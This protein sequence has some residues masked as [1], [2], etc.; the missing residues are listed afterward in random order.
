MKNRYAKI[1]RGIIV[2]LLFIS[3]SACHNL[4]NKDKDDPET[5]Y[6][7]NYEMVRSYLPVMVESIFEQ[8]VTQF[9]EMEV[10]QERVKH[11][12]IIYKITY[13]TSFEGEPKIASGL[14]CVPTGEGEFPVISY[15]NG[16][17]TL[18]KNAPS[19]NPNYELYVLLEMVASTGFIISMPDYLG[20]GSSDNMFHPY[21]HKESTVQTV[22]DMLRAVDELASI[23]NI[24][25]N[26]ELYLTGY[27]QG[28]WATMQVH[29]AIEQEFY[30]EFNLKASAP[31]AGPYDLN[32]INEHILSQEIYPMPYFV[33]YIFNSYMNFEEMTTPIGEVFNPPYDSLI[34]VL[35]D[36]TKSGE[37]INAELTTNVAELFTENYL[38]NF[39]TDT[40][41]TSVL[42][43]LEM[44][45]IKAWNTSVPTRIIHGT[46]DNFVPAQVSVNIYQDFLSQGVSQNRVQLIPMPD[47]DHIE[48]IIPAGL[49]SI[50][51]FLELT[52]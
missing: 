32:F 4:F 13:K 9:P 12:I 35:Y 22:L 7:V 2:T 29:K 51:W 24:S 36:G 14:V 43:T 31:G 21:L 8:L 40:S 46:A 52:E 38:S 19:V 3:F 48:G 45:S 17:N 41:F 16:T 11:G 5:Q 33:G 42:E 10:I 20:F 44:N 34:P 50:G 39:K 25:M 23:R 37:E 30:S 28:G 26:N 18:H 15:Q 27:S 49:I 1:V 6:L 47:A